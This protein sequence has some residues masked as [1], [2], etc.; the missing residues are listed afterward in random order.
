MFNRRYAGTG[1]STSFRVVETL[2]ILRGRVSWKWGRDGWWGYCPLVACLRG[3]RREGN[4]MMPLVLVREDVSHT[5]VKRGAA[6]DRYS[7]R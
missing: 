7:T 3:D 1:F 6:K 2:Q 5:M 4:V